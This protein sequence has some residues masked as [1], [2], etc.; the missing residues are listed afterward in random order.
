[1]MKEGLQWTSG[2]HFLRVGVVKAFLLLGLFSQAE[3]VKDSSNLPLQNPE[4]WVGG[5]LPGASDVAVWNQSA[6]TLGLDVTLSSAGTWGG[7]KITDI[8]GPLTIRLT[9]GLNLNTGTNSFGIDMSEA[10]ADVALVSSNSS[11]INWDSSPLVVTIAENRTLT[12][13]LKFGATDRAEKRGLGTLRLAGANDNGGFTLDLYDGV[14]LL[15]KASTASFHALGG[16]TH[17]IHGGTLRL[18][19]TGGDQIYMTAAVQMSGGVFDLNDRSEAIARLGGT[20]GTITNTGL[21]LSVLTV[22]EAGAAYIGSFSGQILDGSGAVAFVKRGLHTLNM[23]SVSNSYSGGTTVDQGRLNVAADGSLGAST[24]RLTL[25]DGGGI[26]RVAGSTGALDMSREIYLES[27]VGV[28]RAAHSLNIIARGKVTGAGS[29]RIEND[30]GTVELTNG[31]NDYQGSTIIGATG[32]QGLARLNVS[33]NGAL[34]GVAPLIFDTGGTLGSSNVGTLNLQGTTQT[35]ESL[36]T[37]SGRGVIVSVSDSNSQLSN[38]KLIVTGSSSTVFN[39]HFSNAVR[40]EH[41]GTGS[42]TLTGTADNS[43]LMGT[44]GGGK[45]ILAK[46]SST[47]VHGLGGGTHAINNGG[48][49]VLSGTGNDQIYFGATVQINSG[50][51]LDFAGVEYEDVNYVTGSGV[52]TNS[53]ASGTS[54]LMLGTYL[55]SATGNSSFG[56]V[57]QDGSN[58]KMALEKNGLHTLLL[59]GSSTFT[60][61]ARVNSGMLGGIG[62]VGAGPLTIANGA[63]LSPGNNSGSLADLGAGTLSVEGSVAL[64]AGSTF[65]VNLA[66]GGAPAQTD[67][68]KLMGALNLTGASLDLIWGGD[69]SSVFNGTY[70]SSNMFWI[71]EGATSI[72]G[73]FSNFG[74]VADW[75]GFEGVEYATATINGKSF[76]LFYQARSGL[77]G[78]SG[79]TGGNDLLVMALIPEPSKA[80]LF[81]IGLCSLLFHRKRRV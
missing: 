78:P 72:S 68:L 52:I 54:T 32:Y 14:V 20:A 39:G 12:A 35:V 46:N 77:Y 10:T 19:G 56:G 16:G 59:N 9:S 53:G 79:L 2:S 30:T 66:L 76:A 65:R 18:G 42:L 57:I 24:G 5:V 15:E 6:G 26:G 7:I 13:D 70:S 40:L 25:K 60:G 43:G 17:N 58:A 4:S 49:I 8:E 81:A 22:D 33:A 28:I 31:S 21:G 38:S 11:T 41:N 73:A 1:M 23:T 64:E 74:S 63:I 75:G 69:T 29:L 45:L 61:G 62:T 36:E 80:M 71:T 3:I 27:G 47:S 44:V 37:L 50:G 48:T 67:K 51:V 34:G 55:G